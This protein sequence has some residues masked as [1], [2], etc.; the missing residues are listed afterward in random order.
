MDGLSFGL[1]GVGRTVENPAMAILGIFLMAG[2]VEALIEYLVAPWL[3]PEGVT[4]TPSAELIRTMLLRYSAAAV[5][6][7]MCIAYDVDLLKLVG[8]T[9]G[10]PLIGD[11]STGLLIG[12][13]ANFVN[14]FAERWLRP[15]V[16]GK[17]P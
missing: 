3:K 17:K 15:M 16:A 7:V 6:I 11:V 10:W 8:L 12:R 1:Q 2:L 9:S 13:G 14:D 4:L 5:G